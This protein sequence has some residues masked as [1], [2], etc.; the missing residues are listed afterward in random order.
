MAAQKVTYSEISPSEFFYRNRDLAGFSNPSRALY[1]SIRELVENSLDAC[2]QE[3]ILPEVTVKIQ[4][5]PDSA[6]SGD[7]IAYTITVKDN[8]PGIEAKHLPNAFGRVFYGSKYKLKQSRGMFGMGGTMAILYAQITT[9]KPVTISSSFDGKT[10]HILD[11]LIDIQENKPVI[12]K[13]DT[14][15]ASGT[16]TTVELTLMGDYLRAGAK[17][18]DYFKQTALV[19]PYGNITLVDPDSNVITYQRGTN[20][21]PPAPTETLPHPYGIDV[22]AL[23]RLTKQTQD[24]TFVKF[25]T[26]NFHRVGE[27]TAEKFLKFAGFPPSEK[28]KSLSNEDTVKFVNALHQF[29]EFLAPDASCLS[30]LG[31]EILQAGI[32][33]EL[34]PEF[35]ALCVRPPSA[36]S[37]FPFIVEVGLAYGGKNIQ[38]GIK[39]LRFANRIPLL[40]DEANDVA[41]RMINEEIDWK[42]YKIPQEAPIAIITH[43]CSTKV[44]YK[45]VGKEYLADRPELER[46][47]K[48]AI[49]E[50]LRKL[51][52]FVSKKG[53]ME[54]QKKR[55]NIYA[56]YLPLIAKFSTELSGKRK[57]P[58]YRK[59]LKSQEVQDLIGEAGAEEPAEGTQEAVQETTESQ[60]TVEKVKKD[61]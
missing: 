18:L 44:P 23:R 21:M 6:K 19:T 47:L 48:N 51:S 12:L 11:M 29:D 20:T 52:T 27:R 39:L 45:T 15:P 53:S 8:G 1:T 40:Y 54:F 34:S 61:A 31:E 14:K 4:I 41:F 56:K 49:R 57:A 37:G 24:P 16:G 9:N 22:E 50:V 42:R 60:S 36:Y 32:M 55:F 59:L 3:G 2:E 35:V 26:N 28:P 13:H 30:P 25:M 10:M 17:I 33:K 5:A 7:Q 38:P 58:E 46:E 43:V